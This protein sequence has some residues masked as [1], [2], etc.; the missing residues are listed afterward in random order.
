M[1]IFLS[2]ASIASIAIWISCGFNE[3]SKKKDKSNAFIKNNLQID[4]SNQEKA[5]EQKTDE[6]SNDEQKNRLQ[7]TGF[8]RKGGQKNGLQNNGFQ[9]KGGQKNR[10]QDLSNNNNDKNQKLKNNISTIISLLKKNKS[11]LLNFQKDELQSALKVLQ[12]IKVN[13]IAKTY[14][15]VNNTT[16]LKD[17]CAVIYILPKDKKEL[18]LNI[19]IDNYNPDWDV[20]LGQFS[21]LINLIYNED[22]DSIKILINK[23]NA[24]INIIFGN[25]GGSNFPIKAALEQAN[26]DIIKYL[27]TQGAEINIPSHSM[28]GGLVLEN[29]N[30]YG[31]N[32]YHESE[33]KKEKLKKNPY[34]KYIQDLFY[35]NGIHIPKSQSKKVNEIFYY[36]RNDKSSGN[37][38]LSYKI[39]LNQQALINYTK[40]GKLYVQDRYN[41]PEPQMHTIFYDIPNKN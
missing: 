20:N 2:I 39:K 33:E 31:N 36:H 32:I 29:K 3:N 35:F 10:L 13:G 5:D 41:N 34:P 1:N 24:S 25:Q 27:L 19:I 30:V 38:L 12:K 37:V 11:K 21:P 7:N 6:Q 4:D 14:N 26:D 18:L 23:G 15:D 8:Q 16:F 17:L 40:A 9:R 22:L 28:F